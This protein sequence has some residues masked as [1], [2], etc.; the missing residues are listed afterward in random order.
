MK[1]LILFSR[2]YIP[3]NFPEVL[4]ENFLENSGNAEYFFMVQT[5]Y[6]RAKI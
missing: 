6:Y 3:N 2:K 4:Q 5:T 1:T